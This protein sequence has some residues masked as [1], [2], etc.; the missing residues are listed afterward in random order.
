MK[1]FFIFISVSLSLFLFSQSPFEYERTWGTYFGAN[2]GYAVGIHI[3]KGLMFDSQDNFYL[4]GSVETYQ[5]LPDSYFNQFL[6]GGGNAYNA[7]QGGVVNFETGISTL[8]IPFFY[9]YIQSLSSSRSRLE[10]IDSQDNRYYIVLG[11]SPS[12]QATAGAYLSSDPD[13]SSAYKVLLA[14]Y[15]SAGNLL[16]VTYLPSKQEPV[17]VEVDSN[18]QV[19]VSAYTTLSQNVATAGTLQENYDLHYDGAGNIVPNGYL[20]KLSSSGQR[21]WGTYTP[22]GN[23]VAM[24]YYNGALYMVGGPNTN[25]ALNTI[26][27]PGAYQSSLASASITKINAA[28]GLREWGTF[29]GPLPSSGFASINSLAVNETGLYIAGTDYNYDG[30]SFFGTP[31]SYKQYVTGGSDLFLSKF[32]LSGSR[33]WSTYFGSSAEDMNEFDKVI[34]LNGT[35]VYITGNTYGAGSNIATPGSYQPNPES[36][37]N[38]STNLY[39]AK[40]TSSGSLSW[41]SYYGG[42]ASSIS[43]V[44]PINVSFRNNTLYLYGAT[45]SNNGYATEG[46]FMPQRNPSNTNALTS[47]TAKFNNKNTMGTGEAD[48]AK[49]LYLF[50][51]PNHGNFA[52]QGNV[53]TKKNCILK[54]Y[55]SAGRLVTTTKL[56]KQSRQYFEMQSI[57]QKGIYLMEV[58]EN[59]SLL[60]TFK[61]IVN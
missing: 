26:A 49:D 2:G 12:V 4:R 33:E 61:M 51:N 11:S 25:P 50:D 9:G 31:G 21:V 34:A 60:K 6:L 39:F 18:D 55:D 28:N 58:S 22:F 52:L 38:T 37:T 5:N 15:S 36:N 53:F 16:W 7:S 30:A 40:F 3:S 14:K 24:Q 23:S 42:T 45:N 43:L 17:N 10:G 44:I 13:P 54:I 1:K 41:A 57:L 35:D 46:A 29:Y 27:T 48:L 59:K 20:L 56:S 19:Y 47:F 8:G 32:S